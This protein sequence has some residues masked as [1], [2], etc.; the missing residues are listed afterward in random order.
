MSMNYKINEQASY[1]EIEAETKISIQDYCYDITTDTFVIAVKHNR[2]VDYL[3]IN[4]SHEIVQIVAEDQGTNQNFILAPDKSVWICMDALCTKKDGEVVLPLYERARVEKEIV[5]SSLGTDERFFWNGCH[6][7]Y[8]N[9]IFGDE[10]DKML[11]YQFDKN[12]L[13]KNRKTIKLDSLHRAVSYVQEDT[14]YL[15]QLDINKGVFRVFKMIEPGEIVELCEILLMRKYEWCRLVRKQEE[16]YKII[17]GAGNEVRMISSDSQGKIVEEKLLYRLNVTDFYSI[18]DFRALENG[19]VAFSYA[20]VNQSGIIE[21]KNSVAREV[22]G[23][24]DNVLYSENAQI[25]TE[26]KFAFRIMSDGKE[27]HYLATNIDVRG[28]KSRKIY[29]VDKN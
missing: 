9:D 2:G 6:W 14:L 27:N 19:T 5:K 15:S 22:F 17:G 29:V 3:V 25:K 26:N 24:K 21:I 28:G 18:V 11:Q 4:R 1:W 12:G 16:G 20:T 7:G 8:V 13:Y 10:P 23:Q